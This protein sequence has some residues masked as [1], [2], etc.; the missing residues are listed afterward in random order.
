MEWFTLLSEHRCVSTHRINT[1][2][3]RQT[4]HGSYQMTSTI[5]EPRTPFFYIPSLC[6][7]TSVAEDW[8]KT[9]HRWQRMTAAHRRQHHTTAIDQ[10]AIPFKPARQDTAGRRSSRFPRNHKQQQ[11]TH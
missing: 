8:K 5:S 4:G 10:Q 11:T 7:I 3:R 2:I 1:A 6:C 9:R